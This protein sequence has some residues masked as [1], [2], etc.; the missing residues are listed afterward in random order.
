[1]T[2]VRFDRRGDMYAVTFTYDPLVVE[3][4]KL[5]VPLCPHL[6]STAA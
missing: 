1:M 3:M 4:L 6:E 5:I 2:T